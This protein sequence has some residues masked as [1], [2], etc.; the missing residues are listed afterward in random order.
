MPSETPHPALLAFIEA[1]LQ[2]TPPMVEDMLRRTADAIPAALARQTPGERQQSMELTEALRRHG[3]ALVG[4]YVEAL[5]EQAL[6]AAGCES[7][8]AQ[9]APRAATLELVDEDAVAAEVQLSRT[10]EAI[11]SVAEY[12]VRE[13]RT[14]TAALVGDV[15]VAQETNPF[16]PDAHARALQALANALPLSPAHRL[17]LM[18]QAAFPLAQALRRAYAAATSRLEAAGVEPGAYRTIVLNAG[19]RTRWD[20][21]LRPNTN[22]QV[23]RDSLPMPLDPA[24]AP[25]ASAAPAS[26]PAADPRQIE[27]LGRL[28]DSLLRDGKLRQPVQW[29][30]SR[31]QSAALRLLLNEPTLLDGYHHPLWQF[32]DRAAFL[33]DRSPAAQ[34]H[35]TSLVDNLV[36]EP[37]QDERRYQWALERL[38][39]LERHQFEQRRQQ[40]APS[41][42]ELE[43]TEAGLAPPRDAVPTTLDVGNLLTVPADL[44]DTPGA[45]GDA[46][47]A[48]RWLQAQ[49]PGDWC[50]FFLQ[51]EWRALQAIGS[52]PRGELWLYAGDDGR[53]WCLRRG[54]LQRLRAE[55]LAKALLPRSLLERAARRVLK[56]LAPLAE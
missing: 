42:A 14:Y 20:A 36:A 39:A 32:L 55:G 4:R 43:R 37:R 26:A 29:L 50:R 2:Q 3:A 1:E 8:P 46:T 24:P 31:L 25:A 35:L 10:V 7:T 11:A 48:E 5:R 41:L 17:L 12:E 47:E 9:G 54:A 33:L 23:L 34:A 16:R 45:H 53:P 49:R 52:G 28:F 51:G 21:G 38:T 15:D 40:F 30:V 13:L 56:D 6:R 22:L 19:T 18:R 27:L 44:L